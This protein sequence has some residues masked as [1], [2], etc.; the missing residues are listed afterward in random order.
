ML[1]DIFKAENIRISKGDEE[2]CTIDALSANEILNSE[3]VIQ[4]AV[5]FVAA[6]SHD[7]FCFDYFFQAALD[8]KIHLAISAETILIILEKFGREIPDKMLLDLLSLDVTL[9]LRR[10][11]DSNAA[12]IEPEDYIIQNR[13]RSVHYKRRLRNIK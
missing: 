11:S 10:G 3:I 4:H 1:E 8:N 6:F 9:Y 5:T 12:N 13:K 2:T 7:S